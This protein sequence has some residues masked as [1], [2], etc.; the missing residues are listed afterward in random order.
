LAA[1]SVQSSLKAPAAVAI[2][3]P[4]LALGVPVMDTLVV[5]LVRFLERP[6][7]PLFERFL[8]MFK[9]DR[10]HLHHVLEPLVARR[11]RIVAAIYGVVLLF[12]AL[13]LTVALTHNAVLGLVLV[14]LEFLAV[15]ML[16]Q[17]GAT[18]KKRNVA[19]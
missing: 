11:G 1:A 16:R 19:A 12:C 14:G 2:L 6:H 8:A 9:A 3:V 4:I 15:L 5:M 17:L 10:N 13:A 18:F 7:G